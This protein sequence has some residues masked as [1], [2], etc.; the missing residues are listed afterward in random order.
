[1]AGFAGWNFFTN[2]A[3][4]FNTQGVNILIN[5]FFGVTVNAARGIA[6]QVDHAIMHLVNSFTTALNPQITKNYATGNKEALFLLVCRGAKFSY[7][8]LF[9]FALPILME[10]EYVLT[11]WLKLVPKHAVNF[12][13][14]AIIGSLVNIVGKTGYTASMATG[15]IRQYVLWVTSVGCLVFPVTWIVFSLGAPSEST[16]IVFIIVYIAVECVRLWIMKGLQDF[17]VMMFVREVIAKIMLVTALSVPFPLV[18]VSLFPSSLCRL[19]VTTA[20]SVVVFSFFT[21]W[22]GLTQGERSFL[23]GFIKDKLKR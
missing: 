9:L 17:P 13:R 3:Y 5:L 6:T 11:I 19:F 12:V 14:L 2:S 22:I 8:L 18:S 21:C 15:N 16:Y 1:M 4:I 23:F 20:I 10:A 7:L